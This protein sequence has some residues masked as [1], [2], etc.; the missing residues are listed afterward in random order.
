MDQSISFPGG[1]RERC[2]LPNPRNLCTAMSLM[3]LAIA[4]ILATI[5]STAGRAAADTFTVTNNNESGYG[6]LK[7]AILDAK[8]NPGIDFIHFMIPGEEP[9]TVVSENVI[10]S[11]KEISGGSDNRTQSNLRQGEIP[12]GKR[13]SDSGGSGPIRLPIETPPNASREKPALSIESPPAAPTVPT[14]LPKET[15][16]VK[17]PPKSVPKAAGP[18]AKPSPVLTDG[19]PKGSFS[20]SV[21]SFREERN[22]DELLGELK[23]KGFD[24]YTTH[25]ESKEG[26]RWI[27]V[28]VGRDLSRGE[29]DELASKLSGFDN[30]SPWV[31]KK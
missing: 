26:A 1:N 19:A 9:H 27:R 20:V 13:S 14:A 4:V 29:A 18:A 15:I 22:A 6:S 10:Q 16:V 5:L 31:V 8:A 25:V 7:Q 3:L 11:I 17:R 12:R 2:T 21:A 28:N 23:L 24:A 30:L